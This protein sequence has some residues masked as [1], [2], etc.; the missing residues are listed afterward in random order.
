MSTARLLVSFGGQEA[1]DII[2]DE[3]SMREQYNRLVAVLQ[4]VDGIHGRFFELT[5]FQNRANRRADSFVVRVDE[6]KAVDIQE[7]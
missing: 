3:E 7:T 2:G 4:S 5:G 6:I 1:W